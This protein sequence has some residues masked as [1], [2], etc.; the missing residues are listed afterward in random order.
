MF[1]VE[2][3]L[4]RSS[5]QKKLCKKTARGQDSRG[6]TLAR[7]NMNKHGLQAPPLRTAECSQF[8]AKEFQPEILHF[9]TQKMHA[10]EI[11]LRKDKR[12]FESHLRCAAIRSALV[13]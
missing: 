7:C 1:V 10:S 9:V 4:L 12:G 3:I 11:R 13:S 6:L 5:R 2:I 8:A